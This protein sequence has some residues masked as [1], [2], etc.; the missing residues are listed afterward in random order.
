M[1]GFFVPP[2]F[3]SCPHFA[4][5]LFSSAAESQAFQK[6][7]ARNVSDI[8]LCN[9]PISLFP[10]RST[11]CRLRKLR[12]DYCNWP[13]PTSDHWSSRWTSYTAGYGHFGFF[14]ALCHCLPPPL[15]VIHLLPLSVCNITRW[16]QRGGEAD[17]RSS[18]HSYRECAK[19]QQRCESSHFYNKLWISVVA[20]HEKHYKHLYIY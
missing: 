5:L 17:L 18:Q 15:S 8:S 13:T 12:R 11:C 2:L 7:W 6:P 20:A 16:S 3:A 10:I 14:F 4:H 9:S 1:Q 19:K